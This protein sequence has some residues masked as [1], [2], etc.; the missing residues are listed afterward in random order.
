MTVIHFVLVFLNTNTSIT[1]KIPPLTNLPPLAA[2]TMY[3]FASR[4]PFEGHNFNKL[5][6]SEGPRAIQLLQNRSRG[7]LAAYNCLSLVDN[8]WITIVRL[9]PQLETVASSLTCLRQPRGSWHSPGFSSSPHP[10]PGRK[11]ISEKLRGLDVFF[12]VVAEFLLTC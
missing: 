1:L 11:S 2:T 4:L 8:Q 5:N 9:P 12:F 6:V 7:L 10:K 3:E